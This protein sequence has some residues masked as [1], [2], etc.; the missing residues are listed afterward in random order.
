MPRLS[1]EKGLKLFDIAIEQRALDAIEEEKQ[2]PPR[3]VYIR[4]RKVI[5]RVPRKQER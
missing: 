1:W 5:A 3:R 2:R 4:G